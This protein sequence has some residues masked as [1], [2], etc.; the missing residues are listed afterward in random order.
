VLVASVPALGGRLE[1]LADLR[2]RAGWLIF[3]AVGV[4]VAVFFLLPQGAEG[5]R[6]LLYVGS[7]LGGIAF[8]LVNRRLPGLV[9]VAVG[10]ASNL[11]AIAS[12]GGVMPASPGALET[13]GLVADPA[14]F[15]NSVAAPDALLW[16]LGDVFAV[17]GPSWV[18]N[19][20]SPGDVLI[21]LGVAYGV[22]RTCGSRPA[23]AIGRWAQDVAARVRTRP[24]KS[25]TAAR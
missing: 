7:Y 23:V 18:A 21:G 25:S 8:L 3:A 15:T 6:A 16:F 13:A 9:L 19:V 4:Q 22:H 17:G 12:N 1:R 14:R 20:F 11:A 2:F 5:L 10:A 24:R